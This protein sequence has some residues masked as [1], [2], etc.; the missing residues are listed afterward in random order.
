MY[1]IKVNI[2]PDNK[3]PSV[4]ILINLSKETYQ[5]E[6]GNLNYDSLDKFSKNLIATCYTAYNCPCEIK[7]SVEEFESLDEALDK[8]GKVYNF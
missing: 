6:D 1:L 7:A 8:Y 2:T 5:Y 3:L 4:S